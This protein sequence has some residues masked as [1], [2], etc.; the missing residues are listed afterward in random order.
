MRPPNNVSASP[1]ALM[2]DNTRGKGPA[3]QMSMSR[4]PRKRTHLP[5]TCM[6]C[7][8]LTEH[9]DG[10]HTRGRAHDRAHE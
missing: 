9:S 3:R 7:C 1:E 6:H 5:D 2:R 10:A 8:I 4:Y